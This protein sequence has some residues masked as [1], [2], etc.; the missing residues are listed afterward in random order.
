MN[1]IELNSQALALIEESRPLLAITTDIDFSIANEYLQRNKAKQKE[2]VEYWR[3]QIQAGTDAERKKKVM[4]DPLKKG[5]DLVSKAG[6]DYQLELVRKREEEI[7]LREE[8]ARLKAESDKEA[9]VAEAEKA[10][11]AGD[12]QAAS[13]FIDQVQDVQAAPITPVPQAIH[14]VRT[15][16]GSTTWIKSREIIIDESKLL[17]LVTAVASGLLPLGCIAVKTGP[18]KDFFEEREIWEFNQYGVTVKTVS[19]PSTRT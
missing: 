11:A 8:E 17:E 1:E 19:R 3:P 5:Y 9:I 12:F 7:R 2:I 13:D 18:L 10:E 6:S 14:A 16:A 15:V 4:I